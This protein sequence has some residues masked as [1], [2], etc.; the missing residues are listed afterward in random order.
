MILLTGF[1]YDPDPQRRGELIECV[2]R[3]A[4]NARIDEV[5]VFIEDGTDPKTLSLTESIERSKIRLIELGSRATFRFLFDY[6]NQNFS[7]RRV[8]VANADIYFDESLAQLDGYDLSGKLLCLSR[9]DLQPDGSRQ[10]FNHPASQDAWI[11]KSPLPPIKCDF[12]TGIPACD[13]RLAWEA[14]RAG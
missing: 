12:S 1:Y 3:N 8:L 4:E 9:W 2:R 6:A 7:G 10:F 14:Y 11:F 5:H 13:N